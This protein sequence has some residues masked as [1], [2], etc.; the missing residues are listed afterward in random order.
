MRL[1]PSKEHCLVVVNDSE[2]ESVTGKGPRA[3][4]GRGGP[5]ACINDVTCSRLPNTLHTY[6]YNNIT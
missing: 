5:F 2:G 6:T 1:S 3:S 4:G